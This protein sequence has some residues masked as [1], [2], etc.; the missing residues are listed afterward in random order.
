MSAFVLDCSVTVAW[1]FDDE[2]TPETDALLDRLKDDRA[3]VPMLWHL[4]IANVL[5]RAHRHKRISGAQVAAHVNLLSRLPIL[6]DAETQSHAFREILAIAGTQR[7]STYDAAYLELAM[8]RGMALATLDK[9]LVRAARHVDVETLPAES[10]RRH[11][12]L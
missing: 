12:G 7:L 5:A 3:L 11:A 10:A 4:E 9:A 1:L 2:T 8:R 6:T